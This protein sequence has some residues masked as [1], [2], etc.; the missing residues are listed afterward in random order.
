MTVSNADTEDLFEQIRIEESA[1]AEHCVHRRMAD[2]AG[3][4]FAKIR[5][6][7]FAAALLNAAVQ[8]VIELQGPDVATDTVVKI[9]GHLAAANPQQRH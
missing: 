4:P 3:L 1:A 2:I 7:L 9:A 5:A 8:V 6:D